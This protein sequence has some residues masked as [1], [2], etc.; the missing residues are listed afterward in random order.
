MQRQTKLKPRGLVQK[1]REALKKKPQAEAAREISLYQA[2]LNEAKSRPEGHLISPKAFVGRAP[3]TAVDKAFSRLA[4]QGALLRVT[5]GAY[6][7]PVRSR[8]GE[9]APAPEKV[10]SALSKQYGLT[11]V[12]HG[13]AEANA[14]GLTQQ[15]PT[16]KVFLTSGPSR[17][18]RIG[19]AE[20]PLKQAPRWMLALGN[21]PAGAAVR[22]LE[23]I[24]EPHAESAAVELKNKLP[25]SEWEALQSASP[26]LPAWMARAINQAN[27]KTKKVA[28]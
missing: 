10:I 25:A 1:Y 9:R 3:R 2:I 23:W 8:F 13:A 5:R 18:L 21:R 7:A 12:P 24:G 26:M 17:N 15:V 4:Q 14:L 16:R 27:N 28:S 22:A 6:V 11:V 19:A 20:V